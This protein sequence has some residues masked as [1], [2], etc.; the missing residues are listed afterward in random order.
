VTDTRCNQ[1]VQLDARQRLSE[2]SMK[3][4]FLLVAILIVPTS[5]AMAAKVSRANCFNNESVTYGL[6]KWALVFS[7]HYLNGVSQHYVT[8]AAPS[9]P[10]CYI[11][12]SG[13]S[14]T[15]GFRC[16]HYFKKSW[17][18]VGIHG[19]I[20]PTES[21]WDGDLQSNPGTGPWTVTGEHHRWIKPIN[22]FL[23]SYTN[24]HDCTGWNDELPIPIP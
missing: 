12:A 20:F 10:T 8:D 1:S 13:Y 2:N 24:A 18:H 19:S 3:K 4:L 17:R 15:N 21:Y 22:K 9:Y 16:H 14:Q 5:S 7:F 23:L 6:P 11:G